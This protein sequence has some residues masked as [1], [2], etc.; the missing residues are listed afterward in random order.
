MV[1]YILASGLSQ[2]RAVKYVYYLKGTSKILDKE[3]TKI[4]KKDVTQFLKYINTTDK[5][6]EWTKHDYL[7]LTRRLFQ[8]IKEEKTIKSQETKDAIQKICDLKVKRA[9]SREKL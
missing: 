8:W 7:V 9:K 5:F 2:A 6:E 4:T 1:D 3:F